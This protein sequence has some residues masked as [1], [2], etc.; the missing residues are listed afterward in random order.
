MIQD[1]IFEWHGLR[2]ICYCRENFGYISP[3]WKDPPSSDPKY[4]RKR[5]MQIQVTLQCGKYPEPP[6]REGKKNGGCKSRH[7]NDQYFD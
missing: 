4:I 3:N 6:Q 2:W 1:F 7:E 5:A